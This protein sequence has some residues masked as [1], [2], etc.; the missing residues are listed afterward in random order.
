M[1]HKEDGSG[2]LF[3]VCEVDR[4][5]AEIQQCP[6][7]YPDHGA[8]R[9]NWLYF[10]SSFNAISVWV[11]S[12]AAYPLT[13]PLCCLVLTHIVKGRRDHQVISSGE[14]ILLSLF[15]HIVKNH[16]HLPCLVMYYS[17]TNANMIKLSGI[18]KQLFVI[19]P[20]A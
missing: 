15:N 18:K 19:F 11:K 17:P 3:L 6:A 8:P 9:N 5:L 13:V 10:Y 14:T 12:K 7:V 4:Q 20:T 16:V 2:N 1:Q